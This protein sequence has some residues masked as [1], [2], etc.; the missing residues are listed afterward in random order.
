M[1]SIKA[2][3]SKVPML[4]PSPIPISCAEIT[5]GVLSFA[6]SGIMAMQ[7]QLIKFYA[8]CPGHFTLG[9]SHRHEAK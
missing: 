8:F 7:F 9:E 6:A 4:N 3:G 5:L 2:S 1:N